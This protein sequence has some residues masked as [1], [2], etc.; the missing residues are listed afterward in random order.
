MQKIL[1]AILAMALTSG[2]NAQV[3]TGLRVPENSQ[4][5]QYTEWQTAEISFDDG[6]TASIDYRMAMVT[7]KGVACHYDVEVKNNSDLKLDI[8]LKSHYYDKMVK[9]NFGDEIKE[10]LK[11]GKSLVGRLIC[12][13]CKKEKDVDTDDFGHCAACDFWVD[14]YVSK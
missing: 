13:G 8:K 3:V 9:S 6:T 12:Q 2:L 11:P 14:I 4:M 1:T 5:G 10:T 7:R